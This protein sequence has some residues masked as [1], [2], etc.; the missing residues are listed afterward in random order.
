MWYDVMFVCLSVCVFSH[1]QLFWD[2][3]DCS[4]AGPS[5]HG[6]LQA[7]I[8]EWVARPRDQT[9]VSCSWQADSLPLTHW[10]SPH[11]CDITLANELTT[12]THK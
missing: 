7:T 5:V 4:P 9:Q 11:V 10:G 8:L 12:H 1:V 2:P 3:M 6:I